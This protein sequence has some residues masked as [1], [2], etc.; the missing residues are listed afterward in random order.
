MAN[1]TGYLTT[2]YQRI[3]KNCCKEWET[4]RKQFYKWYADQLQA[5]E[6]CCIYCQLPGDATGYYGHTFRKG[7]RGINLEVDRIKSKEPYSPENCVLACYPCNNAKSDVFSY[8]EFVEIGKTIL[9]VKTG[10]GVASL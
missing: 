9:K 5:Q 7:R 2:A 10:G 6:S 3:R 8:T 1:N 4:D